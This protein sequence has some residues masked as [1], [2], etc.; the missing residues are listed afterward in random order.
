MQQ[1]NDPRNI[2]DDS[3]M[4][5]KEMTEEAGAGTK[6]TADA[7]RDKATEIGEKAQDRADAGI[8]KAAGGLES[9]AQK[10]KERTQEA[11]GMPAQAGTKVAEGMEKTAGY[12][13]EHD[14]SAI[15][16]DVETYVKEHPMQAVA[17]AVVGGFLI[18]RIL[19]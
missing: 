5:Y 18:S 17:G 4:A 1:R 15:L 14:T 8:D 11:D 16:D 12:L 2:V 10:L 13:R 9:A 19:R 3:P 6:S 7:A